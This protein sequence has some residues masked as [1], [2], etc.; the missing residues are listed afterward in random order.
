MTGIYDPAM[1]PGDY[2]RVFLFKLKTDTFVLPKTDL[3]G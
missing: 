3:A 2:P 1:P